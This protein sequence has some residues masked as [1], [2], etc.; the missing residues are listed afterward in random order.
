VWPVVDQVACLLQEDAL[1]V[2]QLPKA[3]V[4]ELLPIEL[5]IGQRAR[6]FDRAMHHYY[7]TA[8]GVNDA[9]AVIATGVGFL[10]AVCN[11]LHANPVLRAL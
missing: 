7:A 1:A 8:A 2:W 9:L 6:A 11:W 10:E 5:A 4:I 3:R